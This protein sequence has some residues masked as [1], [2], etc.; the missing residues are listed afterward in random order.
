MPRKDAEW[1]N[2]IDDRILELFRAEGNLNPAA[3]EKFGVTSANHA[4]RRCSKLAKYG[5]LTRIAPGLYAITDDGEA[6]LDEDL[7]ASTLDPVDD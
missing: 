4:S 5:L 2:P 6:Y 7:D 1:M 3:V